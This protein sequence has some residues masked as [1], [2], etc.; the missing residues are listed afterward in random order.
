MSTYNMS[1]TKE[2]ILKLIQLFHDKP[3]LWD[4]KNKNYKMKEIRNLAWAKIKI[5]MN[6][7]RH[8]V[9][10]KMRSLIGQFQREQKKIRV[11][12]TPSQWF[13]YKRMLFLKEPRRCK[14]SKNLK[15]IKETKVIELFQ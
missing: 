9:E 7:E 5:S 6:V 14:N 1:W 10:R 11:R 12:G 4:K 3:E 13:Y 15:P 2:N 8:E